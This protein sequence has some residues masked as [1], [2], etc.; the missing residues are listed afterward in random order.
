MVLCLGFVLVRIPDLQLSLRGRESWL[1][2]A[3]VVFLVCCEF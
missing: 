3:L 1:H 2:F